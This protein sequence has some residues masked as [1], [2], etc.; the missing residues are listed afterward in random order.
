M[1]QPTDKSGSAVCAT[2]VS[3][4]N[5]PLTEG[6]S[7]EGGGKSVQ[8]TGPNLRSTGVIVSFAGDKVRKN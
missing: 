8:S 5:F 3:G 2:K 7:L 6:E 4:R 1:G